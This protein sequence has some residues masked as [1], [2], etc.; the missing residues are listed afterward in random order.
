MFVS[1]IRHHGRS[2]ALARELGLEAVFVSSGAVGNRATAPLRYVAQLARTVVL[3]V[4]H[5]PRVL[6][7][8]AP[9]APLILIGVLYGMVANARVV[10]DAHTKAVVRASGRPNRLLLRLASRADATIVTNAGL[11]GIARDHR[12][13]AVLLDDPPETRSA[14]RQDG[15]DPLI[16]A[17]L[18]WYDDEP[19]QALREA[20]A[21]LPDVT[22]ALT[23][24]APSTVGWP[25]NVTLTGWLSDV[26]FDR[27]MSRATVVLALTT[28][29][30]TMQRAGYEALAYGKP[31]VASDTTVLREYFTGGAVFASASGGSIAQAIREALTNSQS[32]AQEMTALRDEKID[33]FAAGIAQLRRLVEAD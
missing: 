23:G 17:P 30:L 27:L 14:R 13:D 29:D 26:D 5:R 8:M 19:H 28:R 33:A 24:R 10:V 25:A 16:V 12:V 11:A 2:A 20:A 32:L 22:F 4:R 9:P 1:W 3:L 15:D 7:V 18:S 31:L 21:A 6:V